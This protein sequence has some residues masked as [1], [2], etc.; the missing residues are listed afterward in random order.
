MNLHARGRFPIDK[1]IRFYDFAD[2]NQAIQ[3]SES[4]QVVKPVLRMPA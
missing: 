2:I 3:D 4:G 1:L